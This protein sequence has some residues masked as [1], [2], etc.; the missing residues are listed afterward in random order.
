MNKLTE[1]I[2]TLWYMAYGIIAGWGITFTLV[3]IAL[4]LLLVR[5]INLQS[6]IQRL[7]NRQV[8]DNR[9]LSLRITKIDKNL[10]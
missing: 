8:S 2:D 7:E 1:A 10:P 4:I 9:D 5:T 3:V 6:R